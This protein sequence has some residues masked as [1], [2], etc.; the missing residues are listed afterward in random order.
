[1]FRGSSPHTLD[2]KGR[3]VIPSRFREVIR[4]GGGDVA[5]LTQWDKSVYGYTL[6]EWSKVEERILSMS[7]KSDTVRRFRRFFVGSAQECPFD[8]QGRVLIPPALR[9]YASLD[10]EI[11][12]VGD[13]NHFEIWS[14]DN[15][16]LANKAIEDD[17]QKL[18]VRNE[19]AQLGI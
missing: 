14:K 12:L 10:K 17:M 16:E 5:M 7:D 15:W 3:L 8:R 2:E 4:A 6:S 1:M 18:E 11:V 13:L 19:I 9:K